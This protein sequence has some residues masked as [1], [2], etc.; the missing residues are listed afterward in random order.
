MVKSAG[1]ETLF[2][3]HF[4]DEQLAVWQDDEDLENTYDRE[5][6][7]GMGSR[8]LDVTFNENLGAVYHSKETT[9]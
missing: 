6:A 1:N 9:L 3:H 5:I 4:A 8:G 7:R 2:C